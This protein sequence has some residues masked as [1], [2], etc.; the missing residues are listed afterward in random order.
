AETRDEVVGT[1]VVKAR[2]LDVLVEALLTT[3]KLDV[4]TVP[5]SASELDVAD[6]VQQALDRLTPRARIEGARV[7][8]RLPD[9]VL[10]VRADQD[11]LARIMDNLLNNALTYSRHPA[12]VTVLVRARDCVEIA[13]RDHG[14]GIPAEQRE[15]V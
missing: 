14:L 15:R 7:E 12:E 5:R 8:A 3:A 1:L 11:H 13:V 2:E 9:R 6:T 10:R 4:G